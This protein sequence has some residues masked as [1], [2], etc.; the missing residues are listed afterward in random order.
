VAIPT[1]IGYRSALGLRSAAPVVSPGP[2]YPVASASV[3][4][5]GKARALT[6]RCSRRR[7]TPSL[8]Q[9]FLLGAADL[10]SLGNQHC[11]GRTRREFL[12]TLGKGALG[13]TVLGVEQ[14]TR[15]KEKKMKRNLTATLIFLLGIALAGMGVPTAAQTD[16]QIIHLG[17]NIGTDSFQGYYVDTTTVPRTGKDSYEYQLVT[18]DGADR[19]RVALDLVRD[20]RRCTEPPAGQ[21]LPDDCAH[22]SPGTSPGTIHPSEASF[23]KNTSLKLEVFQSDQLLIDRTTETTRYSMEVFLCFKR[24]RTMGQFCDPDDPQN[25]VD[26]GFRTSG[27]ELSQ[28]LAGTWKIRVTPKPGDGGEAEGWFFR[29]RAKLEKAPELPD[30]KQRLLP[31]LRAIVPYE[32]T[33][34]EPDISGVVVATG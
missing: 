32:L 26:D 29:L 34:C 15:R 7:E 31:N 5:I 28:G 8:F 11:D 6:L 13:A 21:N 9:A 20:Y 33:F 18:P 4:A 23:P 22:A 19:L 10:V 12:A 25:E 17:L 3:G 16:P 24:D 30:T 14:N 1:G 2:V 27:K